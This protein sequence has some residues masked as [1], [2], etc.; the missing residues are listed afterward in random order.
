MRTI[1]LSIQFAT[2]L[3]IQFATLRLLDP[4]REKASGPH[5]L[6]NASKISADALFRCTRMLYAVLI[7]RCRPILHPIVYFCN[8]SFF[9]LKVPTLPFF[10][11]LMLS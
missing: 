8:T 6:I 9:L 2:A 3:S 10:K 11:I 4:S 5:F 1:D 7:H